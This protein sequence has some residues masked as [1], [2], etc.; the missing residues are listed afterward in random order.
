VYESQSK[1]ERDAKTEKVYIGNGKEFTF[2]G[3]HGETKA[4]PRPEPVTA[5]VDDEELP[6]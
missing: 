6:F 3:T 5:D 1:D 2:G 4:A